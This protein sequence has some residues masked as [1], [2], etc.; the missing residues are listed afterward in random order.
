MTPTTPEQIKSACNDLAECMMVEHA[1]RE[2]KLDCDKRERLAH[3][4]TMAAKDALKDLS[5]W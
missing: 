5:I 1:I 2:E 3:S 4:N